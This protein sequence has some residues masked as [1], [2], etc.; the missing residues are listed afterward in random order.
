VELSH[1]AVELVDGLVQPC[2]RET[3]AHTPGRRQR[4]RDG[5]DVAHDAVRQLER[6]LALRDDK[7]RL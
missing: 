6:E 1:H 5:E 7:L 3:F 2:R 4:Q